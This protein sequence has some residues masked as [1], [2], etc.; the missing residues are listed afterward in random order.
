M[1]DTIGSTPL[2]G[3]PVDRNVHPKTLAAQLIDDF[4]AFMDCTTGFA[5]M[6]SWE[7]TGETSYYV[8]GI[9]DRPVDEVD[10]IVTHEA[11]KPTLTVATHDVPRAKQGDSVVIN[12]TRYYVSAAKPDGTGVTV[13]VLSTDNV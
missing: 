3:S 8:C 12:G 10:A 6:C 11:A 9:F 1:N 13:L 2:G 4:D 7:P 5:S